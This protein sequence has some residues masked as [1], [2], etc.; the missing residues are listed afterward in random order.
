MVIVPVVVVPVTYSNL[1]NQGCSLRLHICPVVKGVLAGLIMLLLAIVSDSLLGWIVGGHPLWPQI[2]AAK[3]VT[4]PSQIWLL[5]AIAGGI[6]ARIGEV[7]GMRSGRS[8]P[9]ITISH[10][11][12]N[13]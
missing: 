4:D 8:A 10:T 12:P 3:P 2:W 11:E 13:T 6:A 5:S 7:R 1:M 9:A